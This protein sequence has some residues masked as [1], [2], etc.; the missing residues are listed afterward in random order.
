MQFN[1]KG[2]LLKKYTVFDLIDSKDKTPP[3]LNWYK[4]YKREDNIVTLTTQ[5][6]NKFIFDI[7]TGNLLLKVSLNEKENTKWK[8]STYIIG[9]FSLM[10]I[11]LG[12]YIYIKKSNNLHSSYNTIFLAK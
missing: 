10:V 7:N 12:V 11:G 6:S 2:K 3:S 8:L 9:I 5:E 4:N 1:K